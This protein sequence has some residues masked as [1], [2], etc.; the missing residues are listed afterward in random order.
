MTGETVEV[1]ESDVASEALFNC[2]TEVLEKN[3]ADKGIPFFKKETYAITLKEDDAIIGGLVGYFAWSW[4]NVEYIAVRE[5]YRGKGYGK[6]LIDMAETEA[7]KRSCVGVHLTTMSFHA[8]D[9]YKA[10]GYIQYGEIDNF[11][12]G[13]KRMVFRKTFNDD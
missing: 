12:K 4:F 6:K 3:N 5:E 10:L 1:T 8:P 7:R 11:P 13:H 2:L 9:F